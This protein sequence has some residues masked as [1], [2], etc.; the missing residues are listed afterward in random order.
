MESL[1]PKVSKSDTL[2]SKRTSAKPAPRKM[3]RQKKRAP[4]DSSD[5]RPGEKLAVDFHDFERDPGDYKCSML[6]TDR[7]SGYMWH[8]HLQDRTK[9]SLITAFNSLLGYLERQYHIRVKVIECDNEINTTNPQVGMY[10]RSQHFI[11]E[12]SPADT[13]DLDGVAERSGGVVKGKIIAIRESSNLPKSL[14]REICSAAVYLLNCTPR[15]R[16]N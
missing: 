16:L 1:I 14:W 12:P 6:V 15:W 10:L 3:K 8:Y 5:Y 11:W 13:Q 2:K 9:K 7:V 4:R